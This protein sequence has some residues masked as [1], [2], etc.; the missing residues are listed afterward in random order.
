MV[1]IGKKE[2]L[3]FGKNNH[4][5][6]GLLNDFITTIE[7]VEWK[8]DEDVKNTFSNADRIFKNIYVFNITSNR[9]L[10]LVYFKEGEL[11]IAWVGDHNDYTRDLN[12]NKDT[13]RK[14]LKRKGFDV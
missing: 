4:S 10:A 8:N 11:D 14:L 13:I 2:L 5:L 9:V 1:I 3:K 6:L 12:N 7:A